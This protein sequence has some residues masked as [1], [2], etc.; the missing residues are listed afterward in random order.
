M[1]MRALLL[2]HSATMGGAE[3]CLMDVATSLRDSASVLLLE[4]GVFRRRLEAA[5]VD[6]RVVDGGAIHQ[7]RRDS[8]APSAAALAGLWRVTREVAEIAAD[9]DVVHANSQKALIVGSLA[10]VRARKPLVWHLHDIIDPPRFS[11]LNIKA[12]V[13]LANRCVERVLAV[14]R[15]TAD[16]FVRQGG[17]PAKVHVVYNGIDPAAIDAFAPSSEQLR[18]EIGLDGVPV[19]GCFSRLAEWKGQHVLIEAVG[20]LPGVHL[21]LVGGALFGEQAHEQSLRDLVKARGL[22]SRVHFLGQRDDVSALMQC[23]DLIVHP[24]TAPEPFARTLIESMLAGR[25]P[26]ASACGGVPE[27]IESGRTGY[28]FPPGD[29]AALRAILQRLLASPDEVARVAVAARE[30]ARRHFSLPAFVDAVTAHLHDAATSRTSG[31][32]R[33]RA[34][35]ASA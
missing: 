33:R 28:L 12:D 10:M 34:Q 9:F 22:M 21:L 11:R 14:S 2:N 31:R 3:F 24:S 5:G 27:L 32:A 6:V 20:G 1:T 35:E 29:V 26:I 8:V 4:D 7:V 18:R 30:H 25:P 19:I 15:A 16:A 23:V 13:V 17:D